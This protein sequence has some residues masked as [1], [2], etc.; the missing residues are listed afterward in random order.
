MRRLG[1]HY[2]INYKIL[3]KM[4]YIIEYNNLY[5]NNHNTKK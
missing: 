5:K 4:Y 2:E 1:K 3:I